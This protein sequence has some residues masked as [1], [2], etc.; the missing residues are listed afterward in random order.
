MGNPEAEAFTELLRPRRLTA[1]SPSALSFLSSWRSQGLV[2]EDDG[3]LVALPTRAERV[4]WKIG[5]SL[6]PTTTNG[7]PA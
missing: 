6:T 3:W 5:G 2:F 1:L 4:P 7:A